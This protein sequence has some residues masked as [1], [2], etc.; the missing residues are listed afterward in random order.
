MRESTQ[1]LVNELKIKASLLFKKIQQL[2]QTKETITD[3]PEMI[4][5]VSRL[6]NLSFFS[7]KPLEFIL[8]QFEKIQLKHCLNVVAKENGYQDWATLIQELRLGKTGL[9][10]SKVMFKDNADTELYRYGFSEANL[11]AWYNSYEDARNHLKLRKKGYLLVYKNHYFVCQAPHIEGLGLDPKDPDWEKI[12]WDWVHPKD[13][14]AKARLQ[15]KL[16]TGNE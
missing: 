5:V 14:E 3:D 2:L 16:R 7:E 4:A 8:A 10:P 12:D 1:S 15:Q 9:L 6:K 11:N 13:P